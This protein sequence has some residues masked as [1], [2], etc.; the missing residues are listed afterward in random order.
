METSHKIYTNYTHAEQLVRHFPNEAIDLIARKCEL[1]EIVELGA[2]AGRKYGIGPYE[3]LGLE[4]EYKSFGPPPNTSSTESQQ[5]VSPPNVQRYPHRSPQ[6]SRHALPPSPS[7]SSSR[8]SPLTKSRPEYIIIVA[9]GPEDDPVQEHTLSVGKVSV[10]FNVISEEVVRTRL[11]D[12]VAIEENSH[13]SISLQL[14]GVPGGVLQSSEQVT[15]TW[16]RPMA[17]RTH[18]TLFYLVPNEIDTDVLL[19]YTDPAKGLSNIV[20]PKHS[21]GS[22]LTPAKYR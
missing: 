3:P 18:Q 13:G 21:K 2:L 11:Y 22:A 19:G 14:P 4:S 9:N 10:N 5:S 17:H 15:L 20:L 6:S 16:R 8:K 12:G 1:Q 7:T